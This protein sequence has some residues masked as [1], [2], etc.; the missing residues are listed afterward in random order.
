M[1]SPPLLEMRG[2]AKR[3]GDVQANDGVDLTLNG[4]DILG[5]L[6]ENG[7][8]K[9]TL[10]NILFGVYAPDRGRIAVDGR[11]VR[12]HSSADALAHGVG[13]V[14]QHF[15]LVPRHTVMD[16]LMVGQSGRGQGAS[17]G[18]AL[19]SVDF[20]EDD[21]DHTPVIHLP[22]TGATQLVIDR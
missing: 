17:R 13:M 2:I 1:E 15:H 7:A 8:G 6:G 16:N 20:T 10:M 9:T 19:E 22:V 3:F 18:F 11:T 4:G 14:H 5:L 12:I 21:V